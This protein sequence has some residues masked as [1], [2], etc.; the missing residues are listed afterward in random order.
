[1]ARFG[2]RIAL[3]GAV[4]VL[5]IVSAVGIG[6]RLKGHESPTAGYQF[7]E[8]DNFRFEAPSD[9]INGGAEGSNLALLGAPNGGSVAV[10]I[11]PGSS[12]QGA[13]EGV[14]AKLSESIEN[15]SVS[16]VA[17]AMDSEAAVRLVVTGNEPG[18]PALSSKVVVELATRNS[19][20][21]VLILG[22]KPEQVDP[23]IGAF[24]HMVHSFR[25]G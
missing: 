6:S 24:D 10:A 23:L 25:W 2:L 21:V 11:G 12:L 1:M 15:V 3:A 14:V 18:A 4:V 7:V 22:S 16:R 13:E 19:E 20:M 9:W 5:L 8:G 17:S